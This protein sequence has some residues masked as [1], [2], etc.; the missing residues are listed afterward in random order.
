ML[1]ITL[2]PTRVKVGLMGAGEALSRRRSHL[3][4]AGVQPMELS[5][6]DTEGLGKLSLLYVA[7]LDRASSAAL[8][9][10][11]QA[12]GVL[13]NVEDEPALSDFHVPS[14]VRRGNLLL[15]ISSGGRS[16]GLVRFIRE[17]LAG[18]FDASWSERVEEL[19]R[20]RA[21]WRAKGMPSSKV[22]ER[23]RAIAAEW[24]T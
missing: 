8:A 2:D 16:P 7:G 9:A 13:V 14:T 11:A 20:T 10:R 15:A 19:G 18:Q 6:G 3:A 12:L 5:E 1:P 21:A 22:A 24:L 4:E 17:W 23:T